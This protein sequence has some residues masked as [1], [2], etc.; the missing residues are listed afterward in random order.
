MHPAQLR[1]SVEQCLR[2]DPEEDLRLTS[3]VEGL[4]HRRGNAHHGA[5]WRGE[6]DAVEF[7]LADTRERE[8]E[9]HH[10]L[11]RPVEAQRVRH[12]QPIRPLFVPEKYQR[13]V[14]DHDPPSD[15]P[16]YAGPH[17]TGRPDPRRRRGTRAPWRAARRD[18][19]EQLPARERPRAATGHP[20]VC[21]PTWPAS[22]HGDW[23]SG[24]SCGATPRRARWPM[25]PSLMHGTWPTSARSR[26]GPRPSP[27]RHRT[28][29]SN[30]RTSSPPIHRLRRST[31][32]TGQG[33]ASRPPR[34]PPT[35]CGSSGTFATPTWSVRPA[36][37]ARSSCSSSSTS[38]P[39]P[40]CGPPC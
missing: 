1:R 29:R 33:C 2:D 14:R 6:P 34:G 11:D 9:R 5:R 35:T 23:A 22:W 3:D 12:G 32:W 21:L 31:T 30:A 38:T 4:A 24:S 25:M 27:S 15:D 10:D 20:P 36:S 7:G 19:P 8:P 18:Q 40:A 13:T 39:S 37:M 16:S 26:P 28:A 17:L